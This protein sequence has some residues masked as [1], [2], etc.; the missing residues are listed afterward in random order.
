MRHAML[1]WVLV[2]TLLPGASPASGDIVV[3]QH[4]GP[5]YGVVEGSDTWL[6]AR[7]HVAQRFYETHGD[8]YDFLVVLP[9]FNATLSK[10]ADG[11]HVAVRNEVRGLGKPLSSEGGVPFGS[12]ARLKGYIDMKALMSGVPASTQWG[13]IV[14]AHEVA[15][16]W[17]GQVGFKETPSGPRSEALLGKDS[18]HWSFF[19]DSEASVLYGSSWEARGPGSFESVEQRRR[20]SALDLYLMGF[21]S[22]QEVGPLT[23]L[24]PTPQEPSSTSAENL[25][26]PDGTRIS[27]TSRVLGIQNIIHA[28]GPRLPDSA[29]SQKHFRAA[30]ILLTVPGESATPAQLAYAESLRHAFE[31]H[32]FFLTRGR[33]VFETDLVELPPGPVT[34]SPGVELGLSYLLAR[35]SPAGHWGTT[36][37]ASLRETQQALE[38]LRL[39]L[40]SEGASSSLQRAQDSL[41][42]R[43]P[44]DVDGLARL[45]LA[46][47]GTSAAALARLRAWLQPSGSVG[48]SPGY[49]STLLDTALV[50][51]A[52]TLPPAAPD[53][54]PAVT[55]F[56][57]EHQNLDGGWPALPGGPSRFEPTAL[58]L[59]Y[60]ARVPR[61]PAITEAATRAFT[62]FRDHRDSR[63]LFVDAGSRAGATGWAITSLATWRQL[64]AAEALSS[65]EALLSRQR[66][67]GSWEGSVVDTAMAL[68]ALR[69]VLTPN[70]AVSPVDIQLSA[71]QVTA[72]E[73]VL[74]TVRVSNTGYAEARDV[75]VQGFDSSGRPLGTGARLE[76][77]AAGETLPVLLSLDTRNAGGSSQ[78]FLVVD[79]E[80]AIDEGQ[81]S[82]NRAAVP[83]LISAAPTA[84]DLFVQAGG[85][86][87][88]PPAIDRLPAQVVVSA[89]VGNLGK[90]GA[91]PVDLVVRMGTQVLATSQLTLGAQSSQVATWTVQLTTVQAA[92][93]LTVEVD[94]GDTVQ[95]P[96]ETNN[97]RT[98]QLRLSPGV[99]LRVTALTAPGM[100]DQGNDL[101]FQYA[102]TNGGTLEAMSSGRL[103]ILSGSGATIASLPL[104]SQLLNAGG[105]ATGQLVW[106]ANTAGPLRAVLR[107][108]H[109]DDLDPS[110][111]TA[112]ATFEVQPSSLPN[113]LVVEDS[114]S[115]TPEPPQETQ[116]ATVGVT[117]RNSGQSE[118]QGFTV[119]LYLGEPQ[120]GGTLVH[121]EQVA[122]LAPGATLHITGAVTLPQD[123]PK[124]L[125]VVLDGEQALSEFD[126]ADNWSFIPLLPVPIADLVVSAAD[127][128]PDPAFPRENTSVPVTVS[129]LN[130]G[131]QRAE[132]IPVELRRVLSSGSEEPI[133]Q[134]VIPAIEPGQRGEV[135]ISWSTQDLRGPQKLVVLVDPGQTLPEQ[136]TTNNRAE[137]QV[138]VQDAALALSEPYFSPNG[139]GIR[140]VT[141]LSYRL[142]AEASVEA[143]IED[144][145]GKTVRILTAPAAVAASLSWDGRSAE[146]RLVPDGAYRIHA[147]TLAPAPERLLGTLTAVV[148]TN[149][150]PLDSSSPSSLE[151]EGFE[152]TASAVDNHGH[153]AAMPDENGVVFYGE[154]PGSGRCGLYHQPFGG[155]QARRLTP[156]DWPCSAAAEDSGG[157][158]ISPDA[159]RI[160]FHGNRTCPPDG[161]WCIT[162]EILSTADRSLL[163]VATDEA[164]QGR[165]IQYPVAPVFSRDGSRVYFVTEDQSSNA[166]ALEEVRVD[167]TQRRTLARSSSA[168]VELSLSPEG[169]RLAVVDEQGA[170]FF[171]SLSDGTR[172]DFLP[173]QTISEGLYPGWEV[174]TQPRMNLRHGWMASSEALVYA[175]PG[176]L[177]FISGEFEETFLPIAPS[178]ERKELQ[179]G[180]VQKLFVGPSHSLDFNASVAA[181]GVSPIT[182]SAVFRYQPLLSTSPQLW[183]VSA[184]GTARMLLPYDVQGLR[185]S[186][187]GS[188]L[189]GFADAGVSTGTQLSAVTTR[190]NLFV[191]LMSTRTPGSA[192]VA[193]RGA[194]AD[195]NFDAWQL[196][197]RAYGSS[198]PFVA[199]ATSTTPVQN[200]LLTEWIPP[201]P[202]MYEAQ[203]LARDRAGN[204]RTQAVAFGYSLSPAVANV[205][206]SPD[207]FSPNGDGVL[208]MTELRY[209][210]TRATIADLQIL[211]ARNQVVLQQALPH[212]VAGNFTLSWD[213]RD[214]QGQRV[215]DG[216]YTLSIDGTRLS[217]VVDTTPPVAQLTLA[218]TGESG[219][220]APFLFLDVQPQDLG[221]GQTTNLV[222]IVAA[223]T[224]RKIRDAHLKEWA[225]EVSSPQDPLVSR[226]VLMGT[227]PVEDDR[228]I[229]I[230]IELLRGS[231]RLRVKDRAGNQAL[232]PPLRL[233][234]RLFVTLEGRSDSIH[235]HWMLPGQLMPRL[236]SFTNAQATPA[237]VASVPRIADGKYAFG[238]NTTGGTP[239]TSFSVAYRSSAGSWIIDSQNVTALGEAMLLWDASSAGAVT[240]LELRAWDAEGKPF[241]APVAIT[242][243]GSGDGHV[244]HRLACVKTREGE[245]IVLSAFVGD[246]NTQ[247]EDLAPGARWSFTREDTHAVTTVPAELE[248]L[249]T[250][251]GLEVSQT[252]ST[253]F[254]PGCH[255][256]V[257]FVGTHRNGLPLLSTREA[258]NLCKAQVSVSRGGI[259][260]SESF[261]QAIRSAEVFVS[262]LHQE[263]VI[264]RFGP[265]EGTSPLHP[266]D[267][268]LFS[269]APLHTLKARTRLADGTL[270]VTPHNLDPSNPDLLDP[271]CNDEVE[272]RPSQGALQLSRLVRDADAP[273][274][275]I[276]TPVYTAQLTGHGGEGR[277]LQQLHVEVVSASGEVLSQPVVSGVATGDTG[278]N[279]SVHITAQSLPEGA[280]WLRASATWS[281]GSISSPPGQPFFIDRTPAHTVMTRPGPT[282]KLCPESRRGSNG[283]IEQYL[284]VEG[285]V[286]DRHLESYELALRGPGG[287]PQPVFREEFNP[288][289]PSSVQG[290]LGTVNLTQQGSSLELVL[291]ARDVSGSSWCATPVPVQ[292]A[293]PPALEALSLSPALFSPDADGHSDTTDVLF[294][295]DQEV[296][297]TLT[298]QAGAQ[299]HTIF[300]GPVPQGNVALPWN[301][302]L[303]G[304]AHLADG[305]YPL[306]V[307]VMGACDMTAEA[308]TLVRL[309]T[310]APVAR[311]DFPGEGQA[312]A[313][314]F[315]VT[316]EATDENLIRYELS[317]GEGASPSQYT[318]LL[319]APASTSGVLGTVPLA[320]LPPGEYTLRL[321]VEDRVGHTQQV[322]RRFQHQPS[323]LLQ[324]A[325]IVPGLI[326]PDGDGTSDTATLH[327]TLAAPATVSATLLNGSGQPWRVLVE[328][329]SL[330]AQTSQSPITGTGLAGL[331]DGVYSVRVS[332]DSG[333]VTEAA[334]V[335]LE[336]DLSIPHVLLSSPVAG[337]S[338][339][340]EL[341]VEGAVEDNHLESWTLTHVAPGESGEGRLIASGNTS[342]SGLLAVQSGLA[343]GTHQLVLMARD[344]AG[345]SREQ[346]VSFTVD[347]TPPVVSFLSPAAGA[348]LSGAAGPLELRG[349]A[350][351]LHLRSVRLE[352]T[353]VHGTETL[354][355]GV[356]LP[357]DGL[358]H[359]W[360]VGYDAD[361]PVE[362]LLVAEDDAGN[363]AES[364]I[365]LV[366]DSTPPVASL[367]E[368]RGATHGEGL[369]FRGT[370]TDAH[371]ST[372]ELE[373]GRGTPDAPAEL[374]RVASGS[375]PVSSG[376]LTT[377]A[378]VGDGAY[379]ARLRIRDSAGNESLDDAAFTI[380]SSAPLPTPALSASVERPNTVALTWQPSP[381]SDV[382][383]YEVHRAPHA[384]SAVLIATLDGEARSYLD[385]GLPDGRFRYSL[386][387]RDAA[388]NA[389]HPSSE[390]LAEIDAT[391]PRVLWLAPTPDEAVHGTVELQGTAYSP[392][393]FR[394]YRVSIGAG[395]APTAFTLLERS[396]LPVSAGR[397]SELDVLPLPQGSAHTLR[398]EAEDLAGNVSESRVTFTVD[399]LPPTAPV[400]D[401]ATVT[402]AN[403]ALQWHGTAEED[404]LGYVPFRDGA[405]LGTPSNQSPRDL[406]P[407][408]L[409]PT[410][411]SYTDTGVPDGRHS[412]HLVAIDRAGNLSVPSNT[413]EAVVETRAPVARLTEPRTLDRLRHDTWLTA[414]GDDQDITSVRF[415]GRGGPGAPFSAVGAPATHVPFT[416]LLPFS[417]FSGK[418]IELRAIAQDSSN[419]VDPAPA[420]IH[421]LKE[422]IPSPPSVTALVDGN[423]V[424]LSWTDANPAGLLTGFELS[425][426]GELLTLAPDRWPGTATAT[427]TASGS[428]AYA[429]DS[430]GRS[431]AWSPG[432]GLPQAWTLTLNQPVLLKSLTLRTGPSSHVRLEARV[433]GSW[434]VLAPHVQTQPFSYLTHPL[435]SPVEVEA[436]R[437]TFLPSAPG[438]PSLSDVQLEVVPLEHQASTLLSFVTP[439]QHTYRLRSMG[440]GGTPSEAA[441]VSVSIYAPQ[442][443]AAVAET[444]E[445][446]V[447][448]QGHGV[449]PSAQV[450]LFHEEGVIA[451]TTADAQGHFGFTAPLVA[452]LNTF[453]ALATDGAG[454]RSLPS[455]PVTVVNAPAPTAALTLTLGGVEGS[456]VSL[457]LSVGGDS[458]DV[459]GYV[460]VRQGH[461]GTV[462]L[463][464][465]SAGTRSFND[466]GL[467]NGT[468][469]YR[470]HAFNAS[471][472]RGPASN[473]V[474][475]AVEITPPASPVDVAVEPLP[476]GGALEVSWAPGDAR[477]V[478]YRVERALGADGPFV[479][480]AGSERVI[481]TRLVDLPLSEDS[482]YRYRILALDALGNISTPSVIVAGMP[483]DS[484]PP[485]PPRFVRPTVAGQPVTVSSPTVT[486]A[487]LSEPGS[488]VT[489][490]RNGVPHAEAPAGALGVEALP[491]ELSL[492]PMGAGWSSAEG[493]RVAYVVQDSA[494]GAKALAVE[495]RSGELLGTFS[496]P[497]F[498][499]IQE[500][501][502][503][504]DGRHVAIQVLL[505]STFQSAVY[506]A[507]LD[508]GELRRP[509]S[510]PQGS[511]AS[512]TWSSNSRELAYEVT[513]SSVPTSIAVVDTATGSTRWLTGA[514]SAPLMAPRYAPD[515]SSL[516][517]LTRSGATTRLLRMDPVSGSS[518]PLFEA[519]SIE[520]DYA[521]TRDAGR[522]AL[523][524]TYEGKRD[525]YTVSVSTGAAVRLTHGAE[526]ESLP[527]FSWDGRRLAFASGGT[528][529]LHEDGRERRFSG[530]SGLRLAWSQMGELLASRP[531]GLASLEW[532]ARFEFTGVRLEP[533]STVFSATATDAAQR[534]GSPAAPIQI[535]LDATTLP[536]LVAEVQLRPEVP[537]MGHPF[538]AFVTVRNQGGGTAPATTL[539]VAVLSQDG[540]S[541]TPRP[542]SLPVLPAGGVTTAIVPLSHPE[543]HG[544]QILEVIADP[545]QRV[546]DPVRD[547]NR[548][549]YPF[550]LAPD[551]QPVVAVSVSPPSVNASGESLATLTVANPGVV[552]TVDVEV[553]LVTPDGEPVFQVGA[554]EHLAPLEA[555]RSRT[556]T[557]TVSVGQTLAGAYVVKAVVREGTEILSEAGAP[558]TINADRTTHLRL[559][560]S[561]ASYFPGEVI[562]LTA[563][564]R[565]DSTNSFLEGA[566]YLLTVTGPTGQSVLETPTALPLL[567][568]GAHYSARTELSSLGLSPGQYEAQGSI[569]LGSRQLAMVTTHFS[570]EGR[571]LI[572]G[573]ISVLGQGSPP[574]VRAGHAL[575]VDFEAANQGTAPEP[576]LALRI[577]LMDVDT[578]QT[579][580]S[581]ALPVQALEV[582]GSISG[583]HEF[584]TVGLP[585]KGYAAYL[586]AEKP[587]GTVQVLSSASFQL[588]DGQGPVIEPLNFSEGMFLRSLSPGVRAVDTESGVA[589][590]HATS[591]GEPGSMDMDRASGTAFDG[592]WST[593]LSFPEGP[594]TL[595][596]V[597]TDHAGNTGQLSVTVFIDSEPPQVNVTGVTEGALFR[598]A[599]VP[600]VEAMDNHLASVSLFLDGQ[601]F[602]SG[603]PITTDGQHELVIQATD[604]A[605][606][607]TLKTLRFTVDLSAPWISISGVTEGG[608]FRQT[609]TPAV[610]IR[611]RDLVESSIT[612]DGQPFFPGTVVTAEGTH[613]L[614]ARATDRAGNQTERQVSFTLDQTP[615]AIAVTGVSNGT[616][617]SDAV[618]PVIALQDAHLATSQVRLNGAPY[619]S[620]TPL[621]TN[622]QYTLTVR[623]EDFAGWVTERTVQFSIET[624]QVVVS[625]DTSAPFARVLA[626]VRAG[627]CVASASEVLRVG[628]FL[629]THLGGSSKFLQVMTEEEAFLETLRSGVANVVVFVSLSSTGAECSENFWPTEPSPSDTPAVRVRKAWSRELTE[630]IFSGHTGLVVIRPRPEELPSL[631]DAL[632]TDFRGTTSHS[633]VQ[634]P[635][636]LLTPEAFYLS[637]PVG[638]SILKVYPGQTV[639]LYS[640]SN[641]TAAGALNTWGYGRT[642]TLAIDLSSALPATQA[643]N[644][645]VSSVRY[646]EP[647]PPQPAPLGVA[648]IEL[649]MTSQRQP[650]VVHAQETLPPALQALWTH[651]GGSI[652]PGGHGIDWSELELEHSV[653][654]GA[655]FV[656]RLPETPGSHTSTASLTSAQGTPQLLG[657]WQWDITQPLTPA[658][659]ATRVKAAIGELGDPGQ[660]HGIVTL[661][662]GVEARPIAQRGDIEA[663]ITDLLAAA[664]MTRAL[665][666]G[667]APV[668][669]ALGD[670]LRYWEARWFVY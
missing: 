238:L 49:R 216:E 644:A 593:Q 386:V 82:D 88:T 166:F 250:T 441:E 664:D 655:R 414:Q 248:F 422:A 7:Q 130:A 143:R 111:D 133:G 410:S 151:V 188:F 442:L 572:A 391:P 27:A 639:A 342:T 149:R 434:V 364:L 281:D 275:G 445:S 619:V 46:T 270:V 369:V 507:D 75:L 155:A 353:T 504:P 576:S 436:L 63:G 401:S 212:A 642:V 16:Q 206:R 616:Q 390:A 449:P 499:S 93:V 123:A 505:A 520:R 526:P 351:D 288:A 286:S 12:P 573:A 271:D 325:V 394:E 527:A 239:L 660:A 294:S 125:H 625:H 221:S 43:E 80:G 42:T 561:R 515:G 486:L 69:I 554:V 634:F 588:V 10:D 326:S 530:F 300:Q 72:G 160:A 108:Q 334:L 468:Y 550:S 443:E 498:S 126:E 319:S 601:P 636:S 336:I 228:P 457:S 478:A 420:S 343:E 503:S 258:V 158:A 266:I 437:V 518:T 448:L 103:E 115:I 215:P 549:R 627:T 138:S 73:T 77:I 67:D 583:Q 614:L 161:R 152:A 298:V 590:V 553:Q 299:T 510:A 577:A 291:S 455:E 153:A 569:Q 476:S 568:Q 585:L 460:L 22:P 617:Y 273:L 190:D 564:V 33:G 366:L 525:V 546:D 170:L 467:R 225:L 365:S 330:P 55:G 385:A 501:V 377:L 262:A 559:A 502:F 591:T 631:Y 71:T 140:D 19:L 413:R 227:E 171:I 615:P 301:G 575:M 229:P 175:S 517:A 393:D 621:Q 187:G 132:L 303:A 184:A 381:S 230:A 259:S 117:V 581:H 356:S 92:G 404:V 120:A 4:D 618:T 345:H 246:V 646:V 367:T 508:T 122:A 277:S 606:N 489:L 53:A 354:F 524:A 116:P 447:G 180:A 412:Y 471:G 243:T 567:V 485:A 295:V 50:G 500:A 251:G 429:Y 292:V 21:L 363:T 327:V 494:T 495:S 320:S 323:A 425:E 347:A 423:Q 307:R 466:R 376:V 211:D 54:T 114:L 417:Q 556:F 579:V 222:R 547:N 539:S 528:L 452:G 199:V 28:E 359:R 210:L 106:R 317:L 652:L 218:E 201:G 557:R 252:L 605:G 350:E 17:S 480:L 540:Q 578:M 312:L 269:D 430:A 219:L 458:T 318:S 668:R 477:T 176:M 490:L 536:D 202:G 630:Q 37:E 13:A 110:N 101:T 192:S 113:L 328:P 3:M 6:L 522:L 497:S 1:A 432:P 496:S 531:L 157:L 395:P 268:S 156:E 487:G 15:H 597:A 653:Q 306:R 139:D 640:E 667:S 58:V 541:I 94:P 191:R 648:A 253:S 589:S 279:A 102:L 450:E 20:Y 285:A 534:T 440:F 104:A 571:P 352:A 613:V 173:A 509:A 521:V 415:E 236:A 154:E 562:A 150:T 321:V 599:P 512:A 314:S 650:L 611:D 666:G 378:S 287:E 276:H 311:I 11:Q 290:V 565:N 641:A 551:D 137:R 532:G 128:R 595:V 233:D 629:E 647:P 14:L 119:E 135:V 600:V 649:M 315:S 465:S 537:R 669:K 242:S 656:L 167:G 651:Q 592:L 461:E 513:R 8:A 357:S 548:V 544:P 217:V 86:S 147:R 84:P 472:F 40:S 670:L 121:R 24:A 214:G 51:L 234:D 344:R 196:G 172:Q 337:G 85:I 265:F 305:S 622:G 446:T 409:P 340:A 309:D 263:R 623:A 35:Q 310:R 240:E 346:A 459:A 392:S 44:M 324:A 168:P 245:A 32:F 402:G 204:V 438:T 491:L 603:T 74:A 355:S 83:L 289:L 247:P 397:L 30:F 62:Y 418:V 552:R 607:Q 439:G 107:T 533:G 481:T 181:V 195:L 506:I 405:P 159:S 70:L 261:R 371:L 456:D 284:V 145:Q 373:L 574:V 538:D 90:T 302:L 482:L 358:L 200:G 427:S 610:T 257:Q 483:V 205:S 519:A 563:T 78:A 431:T 25:P 18:A 226:P 163:T 118:A 98:V 209:T 185:W 60:L 272:F 141:E 274:C 659:L 492:A 535:T 633:M 308:S 516:F 129:V 186:T 584:S 131:G 602:S 5:A 255:Y 91:P 609:V 29:S 384:G 389:S 451:T 332:A 213:G 626:L 162:L 474:T 335:S 127:I 237:G 316:G 555:G 223:G 264:A 136:R 207:L 523:V 408:A 368:P 479:V 283:V 341:S 637:S 398:L 256:T 220:P 662:D 348:V 87:V 241:K 179:T 470:A 198:G 97:S 144:E 453:Q 134:A 48:L 2:V 61:T 183:T 657:T 511:E 380:D 529:V 424:E 112:T 39:F 57:L 426:A 399:N 372:W 428:P 419:K 169:E 586:L 68:R 203:L 182:G 146:G 254:L 661:L 388:R 164:S 635:A 608:F 339:G 34:D 329:S 47:Q 416:S 370:A 396:L 89:R 45:S 383:A 382:T 643:G 624:V 267:R 488:L 193:F 208:D 331:P 514:A 244:P 79:P 558:L 473:D 189:F 105:T 444:P 628:S 56:L 462:E 587:D 654:L 464:P 379:V 178:L 542:I 9:T 620:G 52:L 297:A 411:R 604:R 375:Q 81:E 95:E 99:D 66:Q 403:I 475:V 333:A 148:D 96:V 632:G 278:V 406:R 194:A 349:H 469:T 338:R 231:F 296:S 232:S 387:A 197:M 174:R 23:L 38:A 124:S 658:E 249:A 560:T 293:T 224:T 59:E 76:S 596:F 31:N 362:L 582:G 570:I 36:P 374:Q 454:N 594:N 64:T 313:S 543:L 463:P 304:G 260:L 435:G 645:L 421:V 360:P 235:Q 100:V 493:L 484:T 282:G 407:Y 566:S 361:G 545:E 280:H 598:S 322:L 26:P 400:L 638:G 165:F 177:E 65:Q 612:L 109:P 433:A 41:Q 663:N 665:S 580:A 142:G